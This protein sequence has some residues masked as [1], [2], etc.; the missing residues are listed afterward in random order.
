LP[1]HAHRLGQ[2]A[3]SRGIP[4]HCGGGPAADAGQWCPAVRAGGGPL[5]L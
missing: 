3:H 5:K 2:V 1:G 4:R